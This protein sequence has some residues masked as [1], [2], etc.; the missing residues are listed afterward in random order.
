MKLAHTA[1]IHLTDN[2]DIEAL[3]LIIKAAESSGC[4]HLL[5][6]GDLFD[7]D[8]AGR[9]LVRAA[10]GA[11]SRF[12]G[13]VWIVPGNHDRDIGS[14]LFADNVKV[15]T[16]I[17][18]VSIDGL[19]LLA[20]PFAENRS[21]YDLIVDGL[22]KREPGRTIALMHGTYRGSSGDNYFPVR[23]GD[24][25]RL[26]LEY[27][28]LGHYHLSF[29][30]KRKGGT[31]ANPGSPRVTRDSDY[32][33]RKFYVYDTET[34]LVEEV[35]LDLPYREYV[36]IPVNYSMKSED[37]LS[38]VEKSIDNIDLKSARKCG[39]KLRI[40][41]SGYWM[42]TDEE[43]NGL[44]EK[45]VIFCAGCGAEPEIRVD[46]ISVIDESIFN[47]SAVNSLLSKIEASGGDEAPQ[48]KEFAVRLISDIHNK[49]L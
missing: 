37:I 12:S 4:S 36:D 33:R 23:P 9:S 30:D 8:R 43:Q 19:S 6:A 3:N 47:S 14:Y 26:G 44:F 22:V 34:S 15:F 40:A 48:L 18:R 45:I 25:E 16:S 31:A 32:G 41:L 24:I 20:V 13:G 49:R 39:L 1:D 35:F 5:I 2:S 11:L 46:G 29:I 27:A 7:S 42:L 28:A 21:L 38:A 17:E 10:S